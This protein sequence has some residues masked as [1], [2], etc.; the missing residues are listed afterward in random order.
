MANYFVYLAAGL[1]PARATTDAA[2]RWVDV[3]EDGQVSRSRHH[4]QCD[5]HGTTCHG[6][7]T[8]SLAVR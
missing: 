2:V 7:I 3:Y 1:V 8:A 6:M 5:H 4:S